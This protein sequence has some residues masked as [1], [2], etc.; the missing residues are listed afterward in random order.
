MWFSRSGKEG[1]SSCIFNATQSLK[2]TCPLTTARIHY[3]MFPGDDID[4]AVLSKVPSYI[5]L[6]VMHNPTRFIHRIHS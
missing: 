4:Y 2:R 1:I 6:Q 3:V 5:G